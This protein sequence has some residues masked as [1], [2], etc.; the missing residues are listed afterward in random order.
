MELAHTRELAH[1]P[2]FLEAGLSD[3]QTDGQKSWPEVLVGNFSQILAHQLR[4]PGSTTQV[5]LD[6]PGYTTL[7]TV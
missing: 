2:T 1:P 5:R 7:K 6:S 3:K 4:A